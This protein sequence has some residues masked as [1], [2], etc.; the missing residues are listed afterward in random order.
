MLDFLRDVFTC[1]FSKSESCKAF[2]SNTRT[3]QYF[4]SSVTYE[5][6]KPLADNYEGLIICLQK[7]TELKTVFSI[8]TSDPPTHNKDNYGD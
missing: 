2:A 3:K 4:P 1:L 5:S 6:E 8:F 7:T